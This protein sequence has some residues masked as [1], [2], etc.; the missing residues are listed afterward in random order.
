MRRAA[1]CREG[2]GKQTERLYHHPR[3]PYTGELPWEGDGHDVRCV[4]PTGYGPRPPI[5]AGHCCIRVHGPTGATRAAGFGGARDH[6]RDG[7]DPPGRGVW[8]GE[9]H[10]QRFGNPPHQHHATTGGVFLH[11]HHLLGRQRTRRNG[12]TGKVAR[13][14]AHA[15]RDRRGRTWDGWRGAPRQ[16]ARTQTPSTRGDERAGEKVARRG[17]GPLMRGVAVPARRTTAAVA[18]CRR[19]DWQ[20]PGEEAPVRP[21]S[22]NAEDTRLTRTSGETRGDPRCQG[23]TTPPHGT[24]VQPGRARRCRAVVCTARARDGAVVPLSRGERPRYGA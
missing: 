16:A 23:G 12:L 3:G 19:D 14:G 21:R 13:G 24:R 2:V 10:R 17:T 18:N 9:V 1:P 22:G 4:P 6:G 15:T 7:G 5:R 11:G 8:C 20:D